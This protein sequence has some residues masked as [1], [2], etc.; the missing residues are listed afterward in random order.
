MSGAISEALPL[1]PAI[2]ELESLIAPTYWALALGGILCEPHPFEAR[3]FMVRTASEI[4][5]LPPGQ[6]LGRLGSE[7]ES[8]QRAKPCRYPTE[9][10]MAHLPG[11]LRGLAEG[12][13]LNPDRTGCEESSRPSPIPP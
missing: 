3:K 12:Q 4:C 8:R 11:S 10:A 6:A 5:S 13:D 9:Y 1:R 7:Q 2:P